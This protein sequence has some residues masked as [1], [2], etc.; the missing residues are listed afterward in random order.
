MDNFSYFHL[1]N[2]RIRKTPSDGEETLLTVHAGKDL[3]DVLINAAIVLEI[4]E[5]RALEYDP[6]DVEII[7][8]YYDNDEKEQDYD[9]ADQ[10]EAYYD[11]KN[12]FVVDYSKY[13]QEGETISDPL[14]RGFYQ[15]MLHNRIKWGVKPPKKYQ[16]KAKVRY[17]TITFENYK[18]FECPICNGKG[19][20]VD[21]MDKDGMFKVASGIVKIAQRVVKD[22]MT[23]KQ[24]QLFDLDYGKEIKKDSQ[25]F[26]N[27][28]EQ[29]FNSIRMT[30]S[31]VEDDYL[32]EQQEVI[33]NLQNDE[34]LQALITDKVSRHPTNPTII[35][36]QLRIRTMS[37]E[38]LFQIGV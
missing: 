29:L 20:F 38:Q 37:E 3:I 32:N 14:P 13:F 7:D 21:I 22:L 31:E 11:D 35:I 16:V 23:E 2:H 1:C 24:S 12:E 36:I 18:P 30:I 33:R 6:K 25:R 27:D 15:A 4:L 9:D 10:G 5:V 17:T 19:W 8:F 34:I 26:S 28:D